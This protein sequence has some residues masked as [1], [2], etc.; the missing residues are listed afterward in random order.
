[1]D[2]IGSLDSLP[3]LF[4][5]ALSFCYYQREMI[6]LKHPPG[7]MTHFISYGYGYFYLKSLE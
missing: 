2:C 7:R 4:K 1:M 5:L 3:P 6:Q